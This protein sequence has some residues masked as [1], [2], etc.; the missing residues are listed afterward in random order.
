MSDIK[1]RLDEPKELEFDLNISGSKEQPEQMR[2]IIEPLTEDLEL[3]VICKIVRDNDSVKVFV[4]KLLNLFRQGTY[5]GSLE[6]VLENRLFVPFREMITLEEPPK[7]EVTYVEKEKLIEKAKEPVSVK[8]SLQSV[9]DEKLNIPDV[10]KDVLIEEIKEE[11]PKKKYKFKSLEN[12]FK[13]G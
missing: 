3:S 1:I 4:P 11:K 13:K 2:F 12:P 10:K 7:A 6:I 8:V 5:R 9:I